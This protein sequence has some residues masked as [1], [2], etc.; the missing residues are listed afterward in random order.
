MKRITIK[1]IA[2]LAGVSISTVS[3]AL[4]DHPDLSSDIIQKIKSIADEQHYIPNTTAL[5]LKSKNSKLIALIVPE[6]SMFYIPEIIKA[7]SELSLKN[8]YRLLILSSDENSD[9]E[10]ENIKIS[11]QSG[12][13]GI[14]VS[15][16]NNS[17]I[18][19]HIQSLLDLGIS[20]VL[21]DKTV[22]HPMVDTV[23]IQDE[24]V[25]H[26][27]IQFLSDHQCNPIL[28]VLGNP[29][30]SITQARKRGIE[31]FAQKKSD[32]DIQFC[33]ANNSFEAKHNTKKFL[34]SNQSINGLFLMSDEILL[35]VSEL[36]RQSS[37][38]S[39][40]RQVITISEGW[41]P[42][43]IEFP[44]H[45]YVQSGKEMAHS[46]LDLLFQKIKS[47][48]EN[49]SAQHRIIPLEL[50]KNSFCDLDEV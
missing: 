42:N 7:V 41:L 9:K 14:L 11:I 40:I 34:Q 25:A 29:G 44:L 49:L 5:N 20:L 37:S 48:Q 47:S 28:C 15:L 12:V 19:D 16:C 23:T 45:F 36:F 43:L 4:H 8:G 24:L 10:I 1:D 26:E 6:I 18:Q 27:A 30:L 50:R 46:A 31:Q 32:L 35:G 2:R 33:F 38:V 3:R 13:E 17:R 21:F 22:D 39:G